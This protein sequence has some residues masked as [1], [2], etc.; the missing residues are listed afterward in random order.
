MR[1]IIQIITNDQHSLIALCNDGT[2]L[3][4]TISGGV[5]GWLVDS[6]SFVPQPTKTVKGKQ[7]IQTYPN[8]FEEQFEILWIAKGRKGHKEGA[9]KIYARM[10]TGESSEDLI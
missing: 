4:E 6:L 3:R 9:K 2:I 10:A 8:N 7:V 5:D 1:K